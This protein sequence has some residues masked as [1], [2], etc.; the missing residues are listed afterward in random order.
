M[1]NDQDHGERNAADSNS[2]SR[3]RADDES[4]VTVVTGP[5]ARGVGAVPPL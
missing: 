1:H 2:S 4:A 5:S 3:R